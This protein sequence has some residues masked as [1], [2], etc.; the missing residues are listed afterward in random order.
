MHKRDLLF[1]GILTLKGLG[2]TA[3]LHMNGRSVLYKGPG[4]WDNGAGCGKA[5]TLGRAGWCLMAGINYGSK[6]HIALPAAFG[7][8]PWDVFATLLPPKP[9]ST[10]EYLLSFCFRQGTRLHLAL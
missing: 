10:A 4:L 7:E 8:P 1:P 5:L 6:E 2:I 9:V 3:A